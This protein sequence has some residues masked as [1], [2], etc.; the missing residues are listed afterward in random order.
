MSRPVLLM[1]RELGIGGS[2]RQLTETARSLDRSRFTPHVACFHEAG[3]RGAELRAA[4]VPVVHIPVSSFLHPAVLRGAWMFADYLKRHRIQLVHAF[5]YPSNVFAVPAARAAGVP[6]V[7]G[8][9]RAHRSLVPPLYLHPL[10]MTDQLVDGIVVNCEYLRRHLATEEKV[11]R[12]L[13]H[14][15]YNGIDLQRLCPDRPLGRRYRSE[16]RVPPLFTR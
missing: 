2:E 12:R 4:G 9:Q 11:D 15:C 7:L 14:L 3:F 6:V 5:D 13:I 16:N 10:R 8:S 1:A